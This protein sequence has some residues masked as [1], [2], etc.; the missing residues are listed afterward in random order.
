[1]LDFR[2]R[3]DVR[4]LT[5][6]EFLRENGGLILSSML[7]LDAT[8]LLAYNALKEPQVEKRNVNP[9][10]QYRRLGRTNLMVSILGMGGA[11][12]YGP[13]SLNDDPAKIT[14]L[15]D[16]ALETGIN[17]FDTSPDYNTE[18]NFAHLA[19]KR[20]QCFIAT[21]VNTMSAEGT[22][23]EVENSLRTMKTDYI[24]IVQTH[25]KPIEDDWSGILESLNELQKLKAEGKVRF[26]G[27]THHDYNK[28]KR[29]LT[30]H[31]DLIDTVLLLYSFH[32]E[33]L[34]AEEIIT[35]AHSRDIGVIAMKAFMG[36]YESWA[37]RIKEWKSDPTNWARISPLIGKDTSIAQ[38][39][40]KYVL[41]NTEVST[42]IVG[43]RT[44]EEINE[45]SAVPRTVMF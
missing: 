3:K 41:R 31:S 30:S 25:Y 38:A 2:S 4:L 37:E 17:Y 36:G 43:M 44:I 32:T 24:D 29:A 20:E 14:R 22:R 8:K 39:C 40:L 34:G 12:N 15:L 27:F 5:R 21:K 33:H 1:M 6:R 42:A 13:D 18:D 19:S 16:K 35:L 26:V 7:A 28:L 11:L 10:M 23:R 45:N 9:K